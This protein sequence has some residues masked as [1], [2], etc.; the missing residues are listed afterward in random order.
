MKKIFFILLIFIL[1]LSCSK[2]DDL[3]I[4]NNTD[5]SKISTFQWQLNSTT[6]GN[7][8]KIFYNTTVGANTPLIIAIHGGGFVGGNYV[9]ML[10]VNLT[11][12]Y[13]V[14]EQ[15]LIDNNIAYVTIDYKLANESPIGLHYTIAD[16]YSTIEE[17]RKKASVYNFNPDNIILYGISAGASASLRIGLVQGNTRLSYIKGLVCISPQASLDV[18]TWETTIF[19]NYNLYYETEFARPDIQALLYPLYLTTDPQQI[20]SISQQF[21]YNYLNDL[22]IL[23]PPMLLMNITNDFLH[24]PLHINEIKTKANLVNGYECYVA[25]STISSLID[26]PNL[27]IIDFCK[28]KFNN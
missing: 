21:H 27:T 25:Y 17:L 28:S 26:S 6:T 23:D 19:K 9:D 7:T 5:Q 10:P 18:I 11:D 24:H 15:Q 22:D 13:K 16:I 1:F 14:T 12:P 4:P 2:S 3:S 20:V 8:Y